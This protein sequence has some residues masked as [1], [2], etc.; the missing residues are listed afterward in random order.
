MGAAP[1]VPPEEGG[2]EELKIGRGGGTV[3][4]VKPLLEGWMDGDGEL[5]GG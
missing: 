5:V 2:K 4:G 3:T 1:R